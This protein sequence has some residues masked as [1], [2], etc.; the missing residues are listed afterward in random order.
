MPALVE[1]RI[2]PNHR[3]LAVGLLVELRRQATDQVDGGRAFRDVELARV[4]AGRLHHVLVVVEDPRV[5]VVRKR[6][7][8]ALEQ[9]LLPRE[10]EVVARQVGG[11]V[12][13]QVCE[14]AGRG[15]LGDREAVE[16]VDIRTGA[17]ADRSGQLGDVRLRAGDRHHLHAGG[18][19]LLVERVDDVLLAVGVG[20][21]VRGPEK[22]QLGA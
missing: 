15:S 18:L 14:H 2:E 5:G 21:S 19:A 20:R 10:V 8:L 22:G 12:R 16:L 9:G 17:T 3:V 7:R 11:T 13:S 1:P 6:V 4:L